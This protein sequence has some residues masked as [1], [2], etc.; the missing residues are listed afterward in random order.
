[1][2]VRCLSL[3][4]YLDLPTYGLATRSYESLNTLSS[5]CNGLLEPLLL[6]SSLQDL[7]RSHARL[8]Y[9]ARQATL[10]SPLTPTPSLE[11][12][13]MKYMWTLTDWISHYRDKPSEVEGFPQRSWHIEVWLVNEKG[14]L[15]PATVF[16]RVT[17]HLHP[18]FGDR[19][20]QGMIG[21]ISVISMTCLE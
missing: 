2:Y 11:N 14:A 20:T 7:R 10:H 12:D 19:A 16:D 21:L 1:M 13:A 15:V 8:C 17:F 4:L 18:S 9:S 3:R 6:R 5:F